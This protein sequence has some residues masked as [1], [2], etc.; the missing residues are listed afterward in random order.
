MNSRLSELNPYP[1]ARLRALVAGIVPPAGQP[2]IPLYI[3]EPK[4]PAPKVLTDALAQSLD[5]LAKYPLTAGLP[6]LRQACAGWLH[7]R[8]DG[9][10][11]DPDTQILPVLGSREALFSFVQ[12]ALPWIR[13]RRKGPWWF[14][15][16]RFIRF[17]KAQRCLRAAKSSMQ[18]A[19]PRVFC[20]I[21]TAFP[22][23]NGRAAKSSL[24]ARPTTPQAA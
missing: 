11:I 8:Y 19:L 10:R 23:K 17:M 2:E 21:G 9:L 4:H 18:T 24:S 7:R 15:P 12:A 5:A 20:R 13:T 1:F 22:P 6:E 16:I 3:G 14:V